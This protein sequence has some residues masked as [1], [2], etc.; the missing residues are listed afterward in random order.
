MNT[1]PSQVSTSNLRTWEFHSK[2]LYMKIPKKSLIHSLL[3]RGHF[4]QKF[5]A[6]PP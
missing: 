3:F 1:I 4:L 6:C 5:D 2:D